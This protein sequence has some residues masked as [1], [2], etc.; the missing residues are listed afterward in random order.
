MLNNFFA[1]AVRFSSVKNFENRLTFEE[2]KADLG[3][4]FF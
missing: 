3:G 1:I 4:Y 2:V